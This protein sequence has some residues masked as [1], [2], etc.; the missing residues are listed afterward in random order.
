MDRRLAPRLAL[1]ALLVLPGCA[2]YQLAPLSTSHPAH[3][4]AAVAVAPPRSA[5]LG[6]PRTDPLAAPAPAAAAPPEAP[7]AGSAATVVGEGEV[8]TTVPGASQIVLDHDAIEGF[9]EAM[10][11]GYRVEPASLLA[12]VKQGDKVRFTIDI[13]RRA[14]VKLEK[15]H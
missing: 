5:T 14:I 4:D 6:I 10:T 11:M 1:V 3:P 15:L 13:Q 8:I 12:G 2:R 7:T 9:M